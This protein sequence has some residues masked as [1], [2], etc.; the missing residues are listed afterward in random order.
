MHARRGP[1]QDRNARLGVTRN[2]SFEF[3]VACDWS[4]SS[5]LIFAGSREGRYFTVTALLLVPPKL[6]RTVM[7]C[8]FT[9]QVN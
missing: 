3:T 1:G 9:D 6:L 8:G 2:N 7:F 4:R 5:I